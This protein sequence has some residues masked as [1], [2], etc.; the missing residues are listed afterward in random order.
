VPDRNYVL[1]P[2]NII[3]KKKKKKNIDSGHVEN[4]WKAGNQLKKK[5]G[6]PHSSF[7]EYVFHIHKGGD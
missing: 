1:K 7:D 3:S 6:S 4:T 2:Q 5:D